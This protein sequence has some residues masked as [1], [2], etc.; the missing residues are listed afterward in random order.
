[1]HNG[2]LMSEG[3]KMSKS[4]G[5]FYTVHELLKVFPGE[6]IRLVLL[7]THYRQPLDFTK[8]SISEARRTLDRWYRMVDSFKGETEVP[9]RVTAALCDDINTPQALAEIH[10]CARVGDTEKLFAGARFLGLMKQDPEEWFKWRPVESEGNNLDT[11]AIEALIG[12]R[13]EAREGKNFQR[14]D[15][16]R[17]D[18]AAQGIILEDGPGGTIWR[19]C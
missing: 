12:E 6:A 4:L 19:R 8:A 15:A 1:M 18:L 13:S 17:D 7:Q 10:K 16:I 2:Y 3:E 9:E 11:A 5:N 14:S